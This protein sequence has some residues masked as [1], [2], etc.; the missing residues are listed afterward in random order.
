MSYDS[1]VPKPDQGQYGEEK[2]NGDDEV[3]IDA[4][5]PPSQ[6]A[7]GNHRLPARFQQM[8]DISILLQSDVSQP[9]FTES[10]SK[11]INGRLKKVPSKFLQSR[12]SQAE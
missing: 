9:P 6:N 4:L 10:Q 3:D 5:G 2:N 1:Q 12:M 11:E 7:A 8:A